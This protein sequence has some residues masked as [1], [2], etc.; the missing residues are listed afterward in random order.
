MLFLFEN[1]CLI[2][3][4]APN[5]FP[6][7]LITPPALRGLIIKEINR[8]GKKIEG[9]FY[10]KELRSHH[11]ICRIEFEAGDSEGS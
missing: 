4:N 11:V 10:R 3:L 6:H 8:F 5:L 1:Y 7:D 9:S 2:M